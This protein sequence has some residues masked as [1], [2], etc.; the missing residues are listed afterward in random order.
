MNVDHRFTQTTTQYA[1]DDLETMSEAK[2]YQAH[3][4]ELL[5][6]H[7]GSRVLEV[8]CGIGTTSLRL[9]EIA[10]RLTCIEPNPN[11]VTRARA[12][13]DGNPRI[14]LRICHLE[15]CDRDEL[16][17]E[18]FDTIVCVNVLEH[19]EDDI[20][21]LRL[22]RD[23]VAPTGGRVLIFVPAI[24]AAYGPLDAALGHHRRYSKRTLGAAFDAAGL[25]LVT[26]RYTNPIGLLGW[27]YNAHVSRTTEHTSGQVRLFEQFVAPWALPLD[28]VVAPPIGLSLFAVGRARVHAA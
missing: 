25:D 3:V 4:F 10:E 14:T 22:F 26:M 17:R 13:L 28:R 1:A 23:L 27:M 21:A 11:C 2:R 5:R 9:A 8:G 24:Q 18:R 12:A 19:I 16:L 20:R 6:P 15:E 7:V